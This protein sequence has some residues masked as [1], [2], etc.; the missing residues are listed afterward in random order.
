MYK[1]IKEK[2]K[3]RKRDEALQIL[4]VYMYIVLRRHKWDMKRI[5]IL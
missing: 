2:M 1:L 3:Y 4:Y 5:F